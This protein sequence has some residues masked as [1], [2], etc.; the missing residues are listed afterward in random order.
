MSY[1]QQ[2]I[3]ALIITISIEMLVLFWGIRN[4][5]KI[6]S[7]TLSNKTLFFSG[8]WS[9]GA[10]LP[11]LWF[12]LPSLI[13]SPVPF[14]IVGEI[15]VFLLESLFYLRALKLSLREACGL[16]LACNMTSYLLGLIIF[17]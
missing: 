7:S 10:T 5:L 1:E 8:F 4:G 2:F 17:R 11:Y 14:H 3:Q 12:I 13:S 16:S 9:S 15:S 6:P